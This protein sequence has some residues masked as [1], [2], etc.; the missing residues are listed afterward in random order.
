MD[1]P[2]DRETVQHTD[3]MGVLLERAEFVRSVLLQAMEVIRDPATGR[4]EALEAGWPIVE[5]DATRVA[6]AAKVI[7]DLHGRLFKN[8]KSR[9]WL[10]FVR[11]IDHA[12]RHANET[13]GSEFD[14]ERAKIARES[15]RRSFP[16][17]EQKLTDPALL[18]AI[19]EWRKQ[20]P[21]GT[22]T[23]TVSKH[24]VAVHEAVKLF[25]P[26]APSAESISKV[27]REDFPHALWNAQNTKR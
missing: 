11:C 9:P 3:V 16:E 13:K 15:Y 27:W 2:E 5:D 6:N 14:R 18:R 24:W 10:M 23:K 21:K 1:R 8:E 22:K 26:D 17:L 20:A 12:A 4:A 19:T 7:N 25:M